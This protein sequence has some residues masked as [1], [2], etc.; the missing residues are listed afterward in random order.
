MV[1]INS[2][3]T[4]NRLYQFVILSIK[5]EKKTHHGNII[6]KTSTKFRDYHPNTSELQK[7]DK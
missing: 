1:E 4:I 2:E 6:E 5:L 7:V 3:L